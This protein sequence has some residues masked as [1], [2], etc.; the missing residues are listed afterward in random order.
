MARIVARTL[1]AAVALGAAV[2][3]PGAADAAGGQATPHVERVRIGTSVRGRA[4]RAIAIGDP[5]AAHS[6]VVVGSIHGNEVAGIAVLPRL[7]ADAVRDGVPT[8]TRLWIVY[9]VNPDGRAAGTRHDARGVDLNRN[10]PFRWTATDDA[11]GNGTCGDTYYPGPR[12]ASEPETRATMAFLA[13]VRPDVTIWYHQHL[14]VVEPLGH[15][16]AVPRAYARAVGLPARQ[17][18]RYHGTATGWQNHAFANS[19]SF[20]VELPAGALG[21]RAVTRHERAVLAALRHVAPNDG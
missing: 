18:P 5:T 12:A 14:R 17:L 13:R 16:L 6:L 10:F 3:P 11:G 15:D 4:I 8:G 1:L 19:T 20:V 21:D 7:A 2:V 9:S